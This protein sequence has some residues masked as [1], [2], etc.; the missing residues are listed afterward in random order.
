MCDAQVW[1]Q[2]SRARDRRE[3]KIPALVPLSSLSSHVFSEQPLD[4]SKKDALRS[5]SSSFSAKDSSDA[6]SRNTASPCGP[7]PEED[8]LVAPKSQANG[9]G[10][11]ED[12]EEEA[13]LVIDEETLDAAAAVAAAADVKPPALPTEVAVKVFWT[14]LF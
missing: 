8:V 1:F 11:L 4:L 2:N 13:P 7:K 10:E 12:A 6:S 14:W 5:T 3:A 9:H